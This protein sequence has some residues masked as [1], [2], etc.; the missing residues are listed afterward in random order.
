MAIDDKRLIVSDFDFDDVKSNLKLFLEAQEEFTDYDFEGSGLSVL[1]DILAY[2]THYLGFNMNMLANEMFLD[3]AALRSSVVSHAKTLGYETAS[4]RAAKAEIDVTLFDSVKT[5]GTIP[6]GTV[7]TTTVD[8]T[9]FQFVTITDHVESSSGSQINFTSIPIY[10]GTFVTTRI[11]VDKTDVE[12]R[13]VIPDNRVDTNTLIV[14]VQ[15]STSDTTSTTYTKTTDISQVSSTSANY[16]IQEVENGKHEIYFGDGVVGKA[17]STG[18]V[19]VMTYVVT[20]SFAANTAAVFSNASTI[21]TVVDVS[22]ATV[23]PAGGGAAAETIQSIKLNAPLD[24]ASQGRCVT[25]EDYKTFIKRFFPN[26]QAV[27]IFG[28]ENGSFDD[29]LGVVSTPEYG[30]VFISIKSTT[31][32]NLT[33][34]EKRN[35]VNDL[36]PFTVASITPIIVDPETLFLILDINAQFNSSLT[37]E[38]PTS[39]ATLI[40]DT[41]VDFNATDLQQ[42]NSVFRHSKVVGLIDDTDKSITGNITRITMGKFLT[43]TLL[44]SIGYTVNFNNP[45]FHPHAGHNGANGGVLASTG[46]KVSG[47]TVNEQFFDD[48]GNG[49][50]R[51]FYLLSGVRTYIDTT[52][53]TVNYETGEIKINP[54]NIISISDVDGASSEQIRITTTPD[55]QDIIPVRNQII[56]LDLTNTSI[57]VTQDTIDTSSSGTRTTTTGTPVSGASSSSTI[58]SY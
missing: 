17:L 56:E 37:N 57:S 40:N 51:V 8:E 15:N 7:F 6:S 48:D 10:E 43:P 19:V 11:T 27:S 31:G 22:V 34:L 14:T 12:Q 28:G 4:V 16:F 20:N 46:F 53:G 42:F 58:S 41:I 23:A 39:I 13:F 55:S 35:L 45:F 26:T 49:N 52:A 44:S 47:D 36:A 25:A 21:D 32:N 5:T 18:N 33:D 3:S 50:L 2:N 30:K 9:D 1:L 38:S 29:T 54:I 24:F